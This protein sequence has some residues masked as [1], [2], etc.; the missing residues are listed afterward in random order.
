MRC[1]GGSLLQRVIHRRTV[2]GVGRRGRGAGC[3]APLPPSSFHFT[4]D[5]CRRLGSTRV[6]AV[7]DGVPPA[8]T[9]STIRCRHTVGPSRPGAR[10]FLLPP[11][12]PQH[13]SPLLVVP[14]GLRRGRAALEVFAGSTGFVTSSRPSSGR[15]Q[16]S[17]PRTRR[18]P[19]LLRVRCA[20]GC[21]AATRPPAPLTP[22]RNDCSAKST[23]G[24]I[25]LALH[26][27]LHRRRPAEGLVSDRAGSRR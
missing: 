1:S 4:A 22:R 9:P 18:R 26:S 20:R 14:H 16:P 2:P 11:P 12:P 27:P 15:S 3:P 21:I 6:G 10:R 25:S 17:P 8:T 24:G 7:A 5:H 13:A 23:I 19:F